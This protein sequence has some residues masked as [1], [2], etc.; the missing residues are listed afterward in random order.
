MEASQIEEKLHSLPFLSAV[1]P[2]DI[3][4]LAETAEPLTCRLGQ[5]VYHAGDA[6]QGFFIILTGRIRVVGTR[7]GR[8]HVVGTL[9]AG[10]H[11]GE[12]AVLLQRGYEFTTRAAE[13]SSL[14]RISDTE[15][16]HLL[17][18][19]P[20]LD[21][22]FRQ[23][24]NEV[25]IRSFLKLFTL[26][27]P[28]SA[29]E[30]KSLLQ[31]LEARAYD[32]GDYVFRQGDEGDAFY[33][34]RSGRVAALAERDGRAVTL[35]EIGPGGFFGELA[36][37]SGNPRQASIRCLEATQLF[38]LGRA[39]FEA[40]VSHESQIKKSI[41]E[42]VAHY[43]TTEALR[44]LFNT[45]EERPATPVLTPAPAA[46]VAAEDVPQPSKRFGR[47][48]YV[49]QHDASD[50]GAASLC[51]VLRCY[52]TAVG[53]SR[54][55][56]LANVSRDG[57]SMASLAH[58][59]DALGFQARGL[60]S[61]NVEALRKLTLPA[62]AHWEGN[63]YVVVYEV[64]TR[65]VLVADPALGVRRID[66][67]EFQKH[68]TGRALELHPTPR[69]EKVEEQVPAF[70]RF[71]PLLGPHR[72]VLLEI[73][74]ATLLLDVL[75]LA[76]PVFTQTVVD[77]VLVQHRPSLLPVVTVGMVIVLLAQTGVS[78][79]RQYLLNHASNRIDLTMLVMFYRH[80]MGLPV[81]YFHKRKIGDFISRFGEA[82]RIRELITG[83]AITTLLDSLMVLVYF[84]LMLYYNA[85]LSMV[86]VAVVPLYA[87]VTGAF[88]P[89]L[90]RQNRDILARHE[91]SQSYLVES[92][93]GIDTV[94]TLAVERGV[95]WKWETL[96]IRTIKAA[97]KG[98]MLRMNLESLSGL[99][100][101]GA[102]ILILYVGATLVLKG[103]LTVGQLMA[104]NLLMAS[105]LAP[106]SRLISLWDQ[107][108]ETLVSVERLN[109]V[110]DSELEEPHL[111]TPRLSLPRLQG[112]LKLE[113]VSFR[114][115][116][117][118][119]NIL[120]N[121][122]LEV[123]PGQTVAIVGRS[124]SGKTT[125]AK[126][127]M[128][129]HRPTSGTVSI[130]GHDL[131]A[132][133]LGSFRRQ[134]G[135]VMQDSFLFS[136]TILEN[137]ALGDPEPDFGRVVQAA[138]LANAQDFIAAMP[139][140]YGTVVG[141]RGMSLS[142]GQRQRIAIARALYQDPRIIVMDE[143]TSSLDLESER[144]IQTNLKKYLADRTAV[145]IAHRL[146]TVQ[147]ADLIVV[148]DEGLIVEKGKHASLME[149]KGLYYYLQS[150]Q[151]H[152]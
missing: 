18:R 102:A 108:Q 29:R 38:R 123:F 87:L 140:G 83:T 121:V 116:N 129:L 97:F 118:D 136:G 145:V 147:E 94:K 76:G 128:G 31:Q 98:R 12:D 137:V 78:A 13:E 80:L 152:L 6:S 69:L 93:S 28:L 138:T 37:M 127:M 117:A 91:E 26:L 131:R 43:H 17:A 65:D 9:Q 85:K 119:K 133:D 111:G 35:H 139:M 107:F 1:E 115:G 49:R 113:N 39:E 74:L 4:R 2:A 122:S 150:Q 134:L 151:L 53:L 40:L 32:E 59:A 114:Y 84:G 41:L 96:Y 27:A 72:W 109:E 61:L 71:L 141:E 99:L 22:Y 34:V 24:L 67:D 11:F 14:V 112:H 81:D 21:D 51:M 92:I 68:W 146:S 103:E 62:I 70:S 45:P 33:I 120:E 110:F 142:G 25:S 57:A 149:A 7:D 44:Q 58:A 23:Y 10:D 82:G 106:V 73:L 89:H 16:R 8:E 52:G 88:T 104:F 55:R 125:L 77:K 66:T 135:V 42:V 46:V 36:L 90:K 63:H 126:L 64:R 148:I 86:V 130:D 19:D 15:F 144:A 75:G 60:Q 5:P 124:G 54:L 95:R 132:V 143:A 105:I 100:N 3:N 56:D 101:R 20:G 50:C 48:P 47:Y 79:I 30:I